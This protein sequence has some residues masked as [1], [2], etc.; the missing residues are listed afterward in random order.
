MALAL[1]LLLTA[2]APVAT[3]Q[4]PVSCGAT[5]GGQ[6]VWDTTANAD[7]TFDSGFWI[8]DREP[9][10]YTVTATDGRGH[11]GTTTLRIMAVRYPK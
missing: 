2:C 7:G 6:A 1:L 5:S 9:G 10:P 8:P 11:L 4:L 3:A